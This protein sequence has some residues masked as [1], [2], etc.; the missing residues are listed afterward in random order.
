[1]ELS[2]YEQDYVGDLRNKEDTYC[3]RTLCTSKCVDELS[4]QID[5]KIAVRT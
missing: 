2:K 3:R 1:M 4:T 5:S